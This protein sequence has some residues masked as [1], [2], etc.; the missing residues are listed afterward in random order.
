M[1]DA[2][3]IHMTKEK[4]RKT[5]D[6][7]G[8]LYRLTQAGKRELLRVK[9]WFADQVGTDVLPTV[10]DEV[11]EDWEEGMVEMD[12]P[13]DPRKD[14]LEEWVDILSCPDPRSVFAYGMYMSLRG[15]IR[16]Y[17]DLATAR[18]WVGKALAYRK[19]IED[20]VY[21]SSSDYYYPPATNEGRQS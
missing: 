5:I 7:I 2:T 17:I 15:F 18:E 13:Y 20:V 6:R 12:E 1:E 4:A 21:R 10:S 16:E 3:R 14:F 19:Q 8:G 11:W 9:E